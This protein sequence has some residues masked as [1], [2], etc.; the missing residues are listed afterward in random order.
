VDTRN[1]ERI[2]LL[3]AKH[4]G[5]PTPEDCRDPLLAYAV[6]ADDLDLTRLLLDAGA[7]P[8][9]ALDAMPEPQFL[10]YVPSK[11]LQNYLGAEPGITLLMLAA[12]LGHDEMVK[13]LLEKGAERFRQSRGKYKLL[14]LYF[15]AWGE[16][17]ECLQT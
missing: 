8:N 3:L 12:G 15:A 14:P 16:H 4:T 17:V 5:P 10:G 1:V 9:T 2:R 11:T 7:D 6:A 13:L